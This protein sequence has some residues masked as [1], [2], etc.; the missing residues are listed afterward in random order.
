[1]EKT[2]NAGAAGGI[3]DV[4]D[5]VAR[6]VAK[7]LESSP[8]VQEL[9]A[10]LAAAEA[11]RDEAVAKA[12]EKQLRD[13][14]TGAANESQA[15]SPARWGITIDP[16]REKNEI[17]PVFTS[18]NGRAYTMKRGQY[19]EV[20]REVVEV[21]NHAV[22]TITV[23]KFDD[24]GMPNGGESHNARRFPYRMHGKAIDET[25]KR[26]LPEGGPKAEETF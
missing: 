2:A 1:M 22:Q 5:V 20:P 9:K 11:A 7:A 12:A 6:E 26:L 21:L 24:R 14:H 3:E 15:S 19:V 10:K 13:Q 8:M 16:A 23:A 4:A 25:G 17:D 18:V